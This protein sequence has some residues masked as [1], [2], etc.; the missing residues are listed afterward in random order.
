MKNNRSIDVRQMMS[1]PD[2]FDIIKVQQFNTAGD[3]LEAGSVI[4]VT[5]L[6]AS[7]DVPIAAG[8]TG[9]LADAVML[10]S[11]DNVTLLGYRRN[12]SALLLVTQP[13]FGNNETDVIV[14]GNGKNLSV[15]NTVGCQI[16]IMGFFNQI[17]IPAAST[18]TVLIAY[19]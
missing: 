5:S 4:S 3:V 17:A 8:S 10:K 19:K 11:G 13:T 1:F 18:S 14:A 16:T 9:V 2:D 12:Y 7:S 6:G 15:L